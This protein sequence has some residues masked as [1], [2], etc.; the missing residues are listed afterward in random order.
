MKKRKSYKIYFI[1]LKPENNKI[2]YVGMT[3]KH[4]EA[5]LYQL[6]HNNQYLVQLI[7]KY[8]SDC[9]GYNTIDIVEIKDKA[10]IKAA[11]SLVLTS[12]GYYE[13]T[14]DASEKV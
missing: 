12:F 11:K 6:S 3:S 8:G 9:L 5:I 4:P 14:I 7:E 2:V 13:Q 1:Y 10:F